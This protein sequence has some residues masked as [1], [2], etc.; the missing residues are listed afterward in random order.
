[1][2]YERFLAKAHNSNPRRCGPIHYRAPARIFW[3]TLRGMMPYK[4]PRGVAALD[5]LKIFEGVPAP[6]DKVRIHPEDRLL[7]VISRST[8][9][10]ALPP[11][12]VQRARARPSQPPS[13]PSDSAS[14]SFLQHTMSLRF[15]LRST[16]CP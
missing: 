12:E 2:K 3:R 4:T 10:L 14:A 6:Y 9:F 7:L 5:R 1:M 8:N 15:H 11:D 16:N 13:S